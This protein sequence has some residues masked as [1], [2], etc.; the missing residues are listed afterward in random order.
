[1]T[2]LVWPGTDHVVLQ[3]VLGHF[4]PAQMLVFRN[5]VPLR[6]LGWAGLCTFVLDYCPLSFSVHFSLL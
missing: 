3:L 2:G 5:F 1:M 4:G 6:R